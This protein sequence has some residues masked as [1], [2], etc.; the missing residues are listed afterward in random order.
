MKF[1]QS[2]NRDEIS[3][4]YTLVLFAKAK[5]IFREI[6]TIFFLLGGGGGGGNSIC[7]CKGTSNSHTLFIGQYLVQFNL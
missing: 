7:Q 2:E 4:V 1:H 3:S 5:L 6:N